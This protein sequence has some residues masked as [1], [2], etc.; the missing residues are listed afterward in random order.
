MKDVQNA[1][2]W[3]YGG[4]DNIHYTP[5]LPFTTSE[6]SDGWDGSSS[7]FF[8]GSE[9]SIS[10]TFLTPD[11]GGV[12]TVE[13]R[14]GDLEMLTVDTPSL[15]RASISVAEQRPGTVSPVGSDLNNLHP[16][17][18]QSGSAYLFQSVDGLDDPT[19]AAAFGWGSVFLP[20]TDIS[21]ENNS[22]DILKPVK[23]RPQYKRIWK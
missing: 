1:I 3:I 7:G 9:A 22:G 10:I 18:K 5:R 17:G 14:S 15:V 16:T 23:T 11:G 21:D 12:R 13:K 8:S 6:S 20:G 4:T 19:D 2:I